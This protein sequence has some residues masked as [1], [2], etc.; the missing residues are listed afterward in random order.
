MAAANAVTAV[1][2]LAVVKAVAAM[3]MAVTMMAVRAMA[4]TMMA[5]TVTATGGIGGGDKDDDDGSGGSSSVSHSVNGSD[6]GGEVMR[7][8]TMTV[9]A[10]MVTEDMSV[11][12]GSSDGQRL[13][14][15]W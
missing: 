9:V 4:V 8:V 3:A 5:A 6:N 2:G 13:R 14:W 11:V 10:A 12:A 1:G 15:Q 7:A